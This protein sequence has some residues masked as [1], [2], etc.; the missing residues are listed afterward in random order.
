MEESSV[1]SNYSLASKTNE[2]EKS[3]RNQVVDLARE[4]IVSG[5]VGGIALIPIRQPFRII[6]LQFALLGRKPKGITIGSLT[7]CGFLRIAT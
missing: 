1:G 4:S 6:H 3:N 5:L 7:R 2:I